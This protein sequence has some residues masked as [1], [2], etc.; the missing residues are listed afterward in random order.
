MIHLAIVIVAFIV[1]CYGVML[2]LGLAFSG[3]GESKGCGCLTMLI[4]GAIALAV[5]MYAC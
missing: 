1:I 2:L 4:A 3:F 5:C